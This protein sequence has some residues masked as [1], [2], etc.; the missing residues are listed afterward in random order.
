VG[1]IL[2]PFP[3]AVD[4]HQA[5]NAEFLEEAGGGT[6]MRQDGKLEDALRER[7]ASYAGDRAQLL[8]L[9]QAARAAT[10]PDAAKAVADIALQE[11]RA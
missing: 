1:S 6:W 4:D 2:I 5:R 9:A 7:L 10:F 3:G 8:A 11:A